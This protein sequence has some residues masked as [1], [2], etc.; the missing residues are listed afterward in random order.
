[1]SLIRKI[2]HMFNDYLDDINVNE[3]ANLI[4]NNMTDTTFNCNVY[5]NIDSDDIE[6]YEKLINLKNKYGDN[7]VVYYNGKEIK[8]PIKLLNTEEITDNKDVKEEDNQMY[9]INLNENNTNDYNLNM[10]TADRDRFIDKCNKNED[11]DNTKMNEFCTKI[12]KNYKD[13]EERIQFNIDSNSIETNTQNRILNI[14]ANNNMEGKYFDIVFG[15][16]NHL[17]KPKDFISVNVSN[18]PHSL[19]LTVKSNNFH[20]H[21]IKNGIEVGDI[22]V[23]LIDTKDINN[24]CSNANFIDLLLYKDMVLNYKYVFKSSIHNT[25][26]EVFSPEI[27]F[28]FITKEDKLLKKNNYNCNEYCDGLVNNTCC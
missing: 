9:E 23:Y 27:E 14:N 28:E 21:K 5:A 12:A 15:E 16:K 4:N 6:V 20:Y 17:F 13:I 11:C 25:D 24:E 7:A 3:F 8:T 1:M 2:N 10:E 19:I 18:Y 22:K 26:D